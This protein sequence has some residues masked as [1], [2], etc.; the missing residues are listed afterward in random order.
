MMLHLYA[1]E[2]PPEDEHCPICGGL[3]NA[4]GHCMD[5]RNHDDPYDSWRDE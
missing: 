3:L 2:T 1:D 5:E 4:R